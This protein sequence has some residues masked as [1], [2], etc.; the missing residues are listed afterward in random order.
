[1]CSDDAGFLVGGALVMDGGQTARSRK[2][3]SRNHLS[4]NALIDGLTKRGE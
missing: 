4:A 2:S 1:M 3:E